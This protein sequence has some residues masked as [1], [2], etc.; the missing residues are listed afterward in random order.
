MLIAAILLFAATSAP[1]AEPATACVPADAMLVVAGHPPPDRPGASSPASQPDSQLLFEQL[2]TIAGQ[3]RILPPQARVAG[4]VAACMPLLARYPYAFALMDITARPLPA[5][6]HRLAGMQAAIVFDTGGDNRPL[7]QRIRQLLAAYTNAELSRLET[8]ASDGGTRYRL[9][10]SRL[11]D[12]CVIEWGAMGRQFVVSIGRGAFERILAVHR[13]TSVP[14]ANDPWYR[15]A[16]GLARIDRAYIECFLAAARLRLRLDEAVAGRPREVMQAIGADKLDRSLLTVSADARAVR[17]H[18]I[19]SVDGFDHDVVL[20]EVP[21]ADDPAAA[22]VPPQARRF[23]YLRQ[24]LAVWVRG[25][26]E[27]WLASQ[28]PAT[29]EVLRNGWRR[30]ESEYGF[31][32][33][34]DL[35]AHLGSRLIVH[36][37]PPHPLHIPL[38]WTFLIETDGAEADVRRAIDGMMT[39]AQAALE[40]KAARESGTG[41]AP[42]LR[43]TGDGIWYL[44]LGLAGPALAVTPGWIVISFSPEAVRENFSYVRAAGSAATSRAVDTGG[45]GR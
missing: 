15:S 37:Y 36:D 30:I 8:I 13:G 19:L 2:L 38:L 16:C 21:S 5:G 17:A 26:R 41:I 18:A 45:P 35:L 7:V 3:L 10:D 4:D 22:A 33:E 28:G 9:V 20:S 32:A 40:A 25:V 34:R 27:A 44:Q 23:G 42:Q 11:P 29:S 43:R 24:P 1:P 6:G 39:A 14:L 31:G 12:W